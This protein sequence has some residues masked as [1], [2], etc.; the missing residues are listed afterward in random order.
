MHWPMRILTVPQHA[1]TFSASLRSISSRRR[2]RS[3][4]LRRR[5]WP[6]RFVAGGASGAGGSTGVEDLGFGR[7]HPVEE[8]RAF[9]PLAAAAEGDLHEA[10]DVGLLRF[11][12]FAKF[13]HHAA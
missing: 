7:V 13:N 4:G 5:P 2:G 9:D 1:Q 10:M 12:L 8:G 11:D 6:L 3:F